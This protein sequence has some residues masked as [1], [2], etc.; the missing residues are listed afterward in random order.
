MPWARSRPAPKRMGCLSYSSAVDS[1]MPVSGNERMGVWTCSMSLLDLPPIPP[2]VSDYAMDHK[3]SVV[4]H[5][6]S[7][8]SYSHSLFAFRIMSR[9]ALF[10]LTPLVPPSL[11]PTHSER[12]LKRVH[13][14][15]QIRRMEE[16]PRDGLIGRMN[17]DMNTRPHRRRER[18]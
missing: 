17:I 9:P 2:W 1:T 11:S 6:L 18:G 4:S 10:L 13:V 5:D 3:K 12:L 14:R 15:E 16:N 8:F 7:A